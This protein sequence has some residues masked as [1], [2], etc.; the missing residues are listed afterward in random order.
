MAKEDYSRKLPATTVHLVIVA[1]LLASIFLVPHLPSSAAVE[2][3]RWNKVN[4]PAEGDPGDWVLAS[5]SD[6]RCLAIASDGTILAAVAGLDHSLYKSGNGG[7]SWTPLG[8]VRDAVTDLAISP[9]DPDTIYYA[10]STSVHRSTD[11]GRTFLE[12]PVDLAAAG[13]S[14]K[15]ITSLDVTWADQVIVAIGTRDTDTG[16]FG[17]VM[18]FEDT[19]AP[20]W[21]DTRIGDYDVYAVAF[22]PNYSYDRQLVAVITDET[23]TYAATRIGD[24]DWNAHLDSARLNRDNSE[25][26]GPVALAGSAGIAFPPSY[27]ADALQGGNNFYFVA[28]NTGNGNGDVY[29]IDHLPSGSTVATDLNAGLAFGENNVDISAL[30]VGGDG[31]APTILAGTTE[32]AQ[33]CMSS[34]GGSTWT[35]GRKQPAGEGITSVDLASSGLIYAATEGTGSGVSVSRDNGMTWNQV[36]LIDTTISTILDFAPSP[37]YELDSTLF[38]LTF[39]DGYDLWRSFDGGNSWER[40]LTASPADSINMRMVDLPP[41]YGLASGSVLIAGESEGHPAIWESTDRGQEF[42]R[43]F[44]YDPLTGGSFSIDTWAIADETTLFIGSYDGSQ[45][46]VYRTT[47]GGFTYTGLATA[48]NLSLH[49]LVLSPDYE[50]NGTILAGNN[51]GGIYI[52]EDNGLSFRSITPESPILTGFISVA[53][54]SGYAANRTVYAAS[55]D[56]QIFRYELDSET[57]WEDIGGNTP[58][59]ARFNQL[60]VG[61]SGTLYISYGSP[62]DGL[63]RCLDAAS[64]PAGRFEDV[65][66]GLE[67]N[68]S[69]YGLWRNGSRLWSIDATNN[70]LVTFNDTMTT[71]AI[72]VSP[73]DG[74]IGIGT[75]KDHTVTG[76]TL[77]WEPLSDATS[78]EWQCDY[79]GDF[80]GIPEGLSGTTSA[81]SVRLPDLHP[82]TE[83][84]WRVRAGSPVLSP[85]SEKRSFTTC[86]D[87]EI[88]VLRPEHPAIAAVDVPVAPVFQWTPLAGATAYEMLVATDIHFQDL[89]IIM[90][91]EDSLPVNAWKCDEE[92]DYATTYYWKVRAIGAGSYSPWSS[93]GVFTTAPP[94]PDDSN[95]PDPLPLPSP[96]ENEP[97][98]K[99]PAG[100][101]ASLDITPPPATTIQVTSP[102]GE[103]SLNI[104]G[105]MVYFVG[106]LLAAIV[107]V[108][109]VILVFVIK[110]KR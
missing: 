15:E 96:K 98:V 104:P 99:D 1:L 86:L 60:I 63:G 17:G 62:G 107:L 100:T 81:S 52:S 39:G 3:V 32:N 85:W 61:D 2:N 75:L 20:T 102:A 95:T 12:L 53:F 31:T 11:G 77:D 59:G 13:P 21:K 55:S 72:L 10:T 49:S 110:M 108:L 50:Q 54:D 5:G 23:D 25:A 28:V 22:S 30:G 80:T 57:G 46:R 89:V 45:A 35:A 6:I 47:N 87:T 33:T 71:P 7:N 64:S 24:A 92:L 68:A 34:D 83:Y 90:A 40:I 42:H 67:D 56:G 97:L 41:R 91:G 16:E 65:T 82:A 94:P 88:T 4:I 43:R 69:L 79:D 36:G 51:F 48:G 84:R 105:W 44:T 66:H 76:V 14:G 19:V 26:P 78:Y 109:L 103:L 106:G 73:D 37:H 29:R 9:H 74:E 38:L 101:P 93:N 8:S 27:R 70:R 18:V 58:A